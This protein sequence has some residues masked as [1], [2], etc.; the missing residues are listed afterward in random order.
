MS[1]KQYL[2][3][4]LLATILCW[5][6]WW[7][8]VINIDPF[9]DTGWGLA[10][11]YLSLFLALLGTVSIISFLLRNYFSPEALPLFKYVQS[12]FKDAFLYSLILT[13]LLY[14]QS[15][16]YL[17]WWNIGLVLV[18]IIFYLVFKISLKTEKSS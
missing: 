16:A 2:T 17:R 8:V 3:T 12:S 7:L 18:I 5:L 4:M 11:F 13:V 15:K 1:I 6:A 10:F 9:T 14:L